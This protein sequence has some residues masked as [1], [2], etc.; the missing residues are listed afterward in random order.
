MNRSNLAIF[1]IRLRSAR[2]VKGL[3]QERLGI[4]AGIDESSAS[5]RMNQYETGK[6][7]PDFLMAKKIAEVLDVPTT[8]F[9]TEDDL[10]AEMVLKFHFLT[11]IQKKKV[12]NFIDT[13]E[14]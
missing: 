10:M 8:Y 4:L 5:A 3:S 9:Y 7:A 6:Y 13:I 2:K 14:K 11:Q 12:I 1:P